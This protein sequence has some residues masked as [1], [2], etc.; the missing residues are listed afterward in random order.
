MKLRV[1]RGLPFLQLSRKSNY[2]DIDGARGWARVVV[3]ITHTKF[4]WKSESEREPEVRSQTSKREKWVGTT[5]LEHRLEWQ[6][7]KASIEVDF[8]PSPQWNRQAITT[9]TKQQCGRNLGSNV[10]VSSLAQIRGHQPWVNLVVAMIY[11][12]LL[13]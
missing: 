7:R 3:P 2:R 4:I 13:H 12:S 8:L 5:R 1:W 6:C 9:T 11:A 10:Q